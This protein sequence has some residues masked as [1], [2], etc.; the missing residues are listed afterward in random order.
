MF[1]IRFGKQNLNI[2][3]YIC[4]AVYYKSSLR[5]GLFITIR[6]ILPRPVFQTVVSNPQTLQT[7]LLNAL[8]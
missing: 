5:F 1:L 6:F 4:P 3:G 2:L 7:I 8:L